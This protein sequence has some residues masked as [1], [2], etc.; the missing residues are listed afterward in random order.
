MITPITALEIIKLACVM[1]F[2][3]PVSIIGGSCFL[4]GVCWGI[5]KLLERRGA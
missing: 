4:A 1:A 3:V 2:I 5:C